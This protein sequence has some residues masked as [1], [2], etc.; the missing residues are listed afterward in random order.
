MATAVIGLEI[1]PSRKSVKEVAGEEFSRSAMPNPADHTGSPSSTTAAPMPG[2]L[3]ADMKLE[4]A[5]SIS[6]R[7]SGGR[8]FCFAETPDAAARQMSSKP[9]NGNG[10]QFLLLRHAARFTG[11]PRRASLS[12][13]AAGG[14]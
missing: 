1:E 14:N 12:H 10:R 13:T 4:T 5:F 2:T 9:R 7:F 3:L 11:S 6:A 8:P